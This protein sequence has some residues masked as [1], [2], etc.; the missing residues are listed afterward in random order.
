MTLHT[1]GHGCEDVSQ[2]LAHIDY[3]PCLIRGLLKAE[4]IVPPGLGNPGIRNAEDGREP[5][6]GTLRDNE[7]D[8][9]KHTPMRNE[10]LFGFEQRPRQNSILLEI[11]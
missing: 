1:T 10:S 8:S 7:T 11:A 5:V 4:P 3:T 6:G 2:A 9:K